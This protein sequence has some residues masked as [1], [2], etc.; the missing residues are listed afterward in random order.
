MT[1]RELTIELEK[2]TESE[3]DSDATVFLDISEEAI[4]IKSIRKIVE[5]DFLGDVL[6]VGHPVIC[7]DF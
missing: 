3:L 7:I 4:P 6:D 2:F 5:S 1:Y